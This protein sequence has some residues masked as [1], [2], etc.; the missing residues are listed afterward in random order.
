MIQDRNIARW[1]READISQLNLSPSFVLFVYIKILQIEGCCENIL[2]VRR[3]HFAN[4]ICCGY[5]LCD[6][7]SSFSVKNVILGMRLLLGPKL[8]DCPAAV[9]PW[10]MARYITTRIRLATL[11]K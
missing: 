7:C 11:I 5:G 10:T 6:I 9:L 8:K 3:P 4:A 1:I 2:G